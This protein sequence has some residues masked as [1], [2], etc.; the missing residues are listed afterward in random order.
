[1]HAVF[2]KAAKPANTAPMSSN[3]PLGRAR[4]GDTVV[5]ENPGKSRN[6]APRP[7]GGDFCWESGHLWGRTYH[8]PAWGILDPIHVN[9]PF[10][11]LSRA[12][13]GDTLL[14]FRKFSGTVGAP[15]PRGGYVA[16]N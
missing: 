6:G 7:R 1:M 2:R 12:R 3:L 10:S 9:T 14:P 16:V 8:A 13:V 11:N 4:V 15:R 5:Q